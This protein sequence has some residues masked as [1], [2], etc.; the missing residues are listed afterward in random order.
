[1]DPISI[2]NVCEWCGGAGTSRCGRCHVAYY[3]SREHQMQHWSTHKKV[4]KKSLPPVMPL[5][6]NINLHNTPSMTYSSPDQWNQ[7]IMTA[8][9]NEGINQIA[10]CSSTYDPNTYGMMSERPIDFNVSNPEDEI[11]SSF[12]NELLSSD[13]NFWSLIDSC[14]AQNISDLDMYLEKNVANP[15]SESQN[16][17]LDSYSESAQSNFS[18]EE[19]L[20]LMECASL[21]DICQNVVHD[22]NKF[23]ICVLDRF[24]GSK[25]G[26]LILE[27]VKNL[28]KTGIFKRGEIFSPKTHT[29]HQSVRSDVTTWVDGTESY[30][31]NI[32]NLIQKLDLVVAA[33]NKTPDN[34]ILSTYKLHKRT[35]A[36]TIEFHTFTFCYE[37]IKV[38]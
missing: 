29:P 9:V 23:G 28:Y 3:C 36:C 7:S 15:I 1:M 21:N 38:N 2:P 11:L 35:K 17:P 13:N 12:S 16:Q 6:I 14:S 33:C 10:A 20:N 4:C 24:I 32:G 19:D 34:G 5:P 25:C 37:V 26:S 18:V 27:E 31:R 22:L 30:C 8:S